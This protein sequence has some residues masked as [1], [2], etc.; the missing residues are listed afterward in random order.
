[1]PSIRGVGSPADFRVVNV[2]FPS[3][4]QA[5]LSK[6]DRK[7]GMSGITT[8]AGERAV[9][10]G[11][12]NCHGTIMME[13]LRHAAE[14]TR[15]VTSDRGDWILCRGLATRLPSNAEHLKTNFKSDAHHPLTCCF[16]LAGSGHSSAAA[17]ASRLWAGPADPSQPP[18][19]RQALPPQP[20]RRYTPPDDVVQAAKAIGDLAFAFVSEPRPS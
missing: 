8:I 17:A 19:K 6:Q 15:T 18:C 20:A 1:M 11:D 2:H 9:I 10:L 4:K 13:A 14:G 7:C 16:C 12:L 3:S 5:T